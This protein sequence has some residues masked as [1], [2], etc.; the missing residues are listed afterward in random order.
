MA[1]TG[2]IFSVF[3]KL[4][5][6]NVVE[7]DAEG[8]VNCFDLQAFMQAG[9]IP[10]TTCKLLIK[11]SGGNAVMGVDHYGTIYLTDQA[12]I[13]VTIPLIDS[14]SPVFGSTA[15]GDEI[16]ITGEGF[17]ADVEVTIDGNACTSVVVT[18][19]SLITCDTPAG[20]AGAKALKVSNPNQGWFELTGAFTYRAA[21]TIASISPS[22]G[23]EGDTVTITGTGYFADAD[24]NIPGV[25]VNAV[26]CTNVSLRS[27]TS[28]RCRVPANANGTYDVVV[29]N[30]D[31]LTATLA[32]SFTYATAPIVTSVTP[33][34]G[35]TDGGDNVTIGGT[36]FVDAPTVTIGGAAA[37]NVVF[38]SATEIT[39]DIPAHTGE[40]LVDI[41]VT[42]PSTVGGTLYD[43]FEYFTQVSTTLDDA[44]GADAAEFT[45]IAGHI[46]AFVTSFGELKIKGDVRIGFP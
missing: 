39:C 25:T 20:A 42:N 17:A 24:D 31:G 37:T 34:F 5:G 38:V 6:V 13:G 35:N 27:S 28:I 44:A 12:H 21:P 45:A 18:G 1:E 11:D 23:N 32:A 4:N 30:P 22:T 8:N 9:E 43:S 19:T 40:E 41:V 2:L 16:T 7:F 14:L 36:G 10:S 46:A 26:A 15:G 3:S 33:F 29:T